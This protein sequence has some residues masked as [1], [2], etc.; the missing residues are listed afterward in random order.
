[1]TTDEELRRLRSIGIPDYLAD[2]KTGRITWCADWAHLSDCIAAGLV[3]ARS[4]SAGPG[5]YGHTD[6]FVPVR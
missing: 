2:A 4:V 6:W 3:D 1:M 5:T